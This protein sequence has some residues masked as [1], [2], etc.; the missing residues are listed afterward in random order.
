MGRVEGPALGEEFAE[1]DRVFEE[2]E[3]FVSNF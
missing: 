2:E 3:E 1:R